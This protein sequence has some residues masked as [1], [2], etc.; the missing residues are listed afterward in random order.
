MYIPIHSQ[1]IP[2]AWTHVT[3]NLM[4]VEFPRLMEI[5]ED[6]PDV[7]LLD[8]GHDLAAIS[9]P[10]DEAL[11]ISPLTIPILRAAAAGA[12]VP[13]AENMWTE[14]DLGAE[15]DYLGG[16]LRVGIY[17]ERI[18]CADTANA[19]PRLFDKADTEDG[20]GLLLLRAEE[21]QK[22]AWIVAYAVVGMYH[23]KAVLLGRFLASHAEDGSVPEIKAF[24]TAQEGVVSTGAWSNL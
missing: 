13:P 8:L 3:T 16:R 18:S 19:A 12:I 1:R 21:R 23:G 20:F 2:G 9:N 4:L 5:I 14:F 7:R 17:S 6:L 15:D 24:K 11:K 10:E 22:P